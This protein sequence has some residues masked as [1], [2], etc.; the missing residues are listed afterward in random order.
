MLETLSLWAP[1]YLMEVFIPSLGRFPGLRQLRL[2]AD[3]VRVGYSEADGYEYILNEY[4]AAIFEMVEEHEVA[5]WDWDD[6]AV[7]RASLLRHL[8]SQL[9]CLTLCNFMA[10]R[11]DQA[12]EAA[13]SDATSQALLP[14]LTQLHISSARDAVLAAR[15]P[16][17]AT[18]TIQARSANLTSEALLLPQLTSL[19]L[20]QSSADVPLRCAAMPTLAQLVLQQCRAHACDG[21]HTLQHLTHLELSPLGGLDT[22]M[23]GG[24]AGSLCSLSVTLQPGTARTAP[25]QVAALAAAGAARLTRLVGGHLTALRY[26]GLAGCV[27]PGP[28]CWP[29]STCTSLPPSSATSTCTSQQE[30]NS[31]ACLPHLPTWPELQELVLSHVRPTSVPAQHLAALA[32]AL[33]LRRLQFVDWFALDQKAERVKAEVCGRA[34]KQVSSMGGPLREPQHTLPVFTNL[35]LSPHGCRSCA[36]RCPTARWSAELVGCAEVRR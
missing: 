13:D 22:A 35:M 17:L 5:S 4:D 7:L 36:R 18:L 30:I 27:P 25:Q 26:I 28:L 16:S 6:G 10:V 31:M 33:S 8:P 15:L 23:I 24:L 32:G 1:F 29:C 12:A 14:A 9:D 3:T 11:I 21:W 19:Q 2:D 20:V 34:Q